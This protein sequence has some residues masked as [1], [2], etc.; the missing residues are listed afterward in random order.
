M[1]VLR[2]LLFGDESDQIHLA[3]V[4][5]CVHNLPAT[6]WFRNWVLHSQCSIVETVSCTSHITEHR[7]PKTVLC[8][9]TRKLY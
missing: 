3:D 5:V 2:R 7:L 4:C 6:Y 1:A 9:F 8:T